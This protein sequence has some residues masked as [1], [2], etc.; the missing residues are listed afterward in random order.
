MDEVKYTLKEDE[1]PKKWYNILPDMPGEFAPPIHPATK[2]PIGPD[3]LKAIFPMGLIAQEASMEHYI[4][5]PDEIQEAYL[6]VGRPSPLYRAKRLENAL[7]TPAKIYYKRED[8]SFVGS[9]KSNTAIAQA[10]Y[11]MKEGIERLSTETGAGQW[12]SALSMACTIFD[13]ECLVYMVKVSYEQK[14]YRKYVMKMYD[15]NVIASPSNTTECG[16]KMLEEDPDSTGSLGMA[17]SEAVEVAAKD[18]K[19]NYS[20]GSV[21]NHVMLH[22]TVIGQ[23]VQKQLQMAG[24]ENPD[25][26]IGCAGGGSNFA[27]FAFPMIGEKLKKKNETEFYAVEPK[28]VP[29]MTGFDEGT[30]KFD[31]DFGDTAG[32]TPLIKMYTLGHK[33]VPPPIHAGGLRYH[34]MA[35]TVSHLLNEKVIKAEAYP[36]DDT[37][38]AAK[39]FAKTEGIIPAPET[40]HAIASAIKHARACK[41]KNEEKTIVFNFSGHGL[42]DLGSYASALNF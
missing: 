1:L 7:K 25:V 15:A 42:L 13:L 38:V 4:D 31:Y 16:K 37:F 34:G 19:T 5:I 21:L 32:L 27:G 22:Q 40:T 12:G 39:L 6:R 2:K 28:A 8:V 9:H 18:E 17:I 23:E 35:P 33:F 26:M 11:N 14:P 24:V 29:T 10:Y 3:D 36:Q 41:E 20:L 30:S